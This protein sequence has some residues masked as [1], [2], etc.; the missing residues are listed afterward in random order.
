MMAIIEG[1]SKIIAVDIH[2]SRLEIAKELGATHTI[3]SRTEDLTQLI[4]EITNGV[5]VNFSVDTT[6]VAPVIKASIDVLAIGGVAAPVA[7]TPNSIE[8]NTTLDL[9]FAN[10]SI[11]GILMGDSIP[12]FAIPK[13]IEFHQQGKFAFNKLVKFYKFDEINEASPTPIVVYQLN[14]Y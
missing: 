13:L 6:G 9:V 10:R 2:N 8:L 3:N 4:G 14:L 5:G 11:K 7:V 12:Q 1:C